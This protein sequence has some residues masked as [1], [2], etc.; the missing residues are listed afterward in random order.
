MRKEERWRVEDED[1]NGRL[2][3]GKDEVRKIFII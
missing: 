3:Q 2:A 1:E